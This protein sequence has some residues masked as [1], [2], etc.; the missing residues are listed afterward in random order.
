MT[1]DIWCP[2]RQRTFLCNFGIRST[3]KSS[4]VVN[5]QVEFYIR[6]DQVYHDNFDKIFSLL[7]SF[8]LV[9]FYKASISREEDYQL[10]VSCRIHRIYR[11]CLG[12]LGNTGIWQWCFS[13]VRFK[14]VKKHNKNNVTYTFVLS[15]GDLPGKYL[16]EL[17]IVFIFGSIQF[18]TSDPLIL[19]YISLYAEKTEIEE[20]GL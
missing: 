11:V 13:M 18:P 1:L 19:Y 15:A 6:D 17:V 4:Q 3:V 10:C 7:N 16:I 9:I 2:S 12:I 20:R 14:L 5:S 8:A